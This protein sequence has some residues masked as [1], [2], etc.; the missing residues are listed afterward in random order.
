M[1]LWDEIRDEIRQTL[2]QP[3]ERA[4]FDSDEEHRQAMGMWEMLVAR[5]LGTRHAGQEVFRK[6]DDPA[7]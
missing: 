6:R 7:G 5:L 2:P 3:P 4:L 1:N